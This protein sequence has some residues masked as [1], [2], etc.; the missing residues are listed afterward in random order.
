MG[1]LQAGILRSLFLRGFRPG[2]IIGTSVGALNGAFL[3]FYPD[4]EGVDRLTEIWRGI[5]RERF[6]NLN[7]MRLAYRLA[8]RQHCLFSNEFLQR[9]IAQHTVEDDFA[10]TKVPLHVVVT[11]VASG[12][13]R[14]FSEGSV[15]QAV[16]AST[17]IPGVFCPVEIEGEEFIDG[18]V[19][20]N[21]D[22]E[23]AVALGN[24]DVLA[25]DLSR[26]FHNDAPDNVLRMITRTVDIVMQERVDR[27]MEAL[28]D[29]SRITLLQPEMTRGPGVGDLRHVPRLIE[30]GE[31][32]AEQVVDQCFDARGRL[33]P[34]VVRGR[35]DAP[36][37]AT[38]PSVLT[39]PAA[40][41]VKR[42]RFSF[43]RRVAGSVLEPLP[44]QIEP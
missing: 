15:S 41:D 38:E 2:R 35:V 10:T 11:S 39:G 8:L 22:L 5:E 24:R 43:R 14:V 40:P 7:P 33:R 31:T 6:I 19:V 4:E 3:A 18:G 37:R 9:L 42:P 29:R 21:L 20:A 44:A 12:G 28:R 34:G 30:E 25:I 36:E 32:F 16:L 17:A 27:D 26:C 1:A 23:T 13:K